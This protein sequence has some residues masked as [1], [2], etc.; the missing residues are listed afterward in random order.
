MGMPTLE[1][2]ITAVT[3]NRKFSKALIRHFAAIQPLKSLGSGVDSSTLPFDVLQLVFVDKSEDQTKV[4]GCN[5]DRLFQVEVP[6]PDERTVD[7]G[8][9]SAF[10]KA[11]AYQVQRALT[12]CGLPPQI[13]EQLLR[14]NSHWV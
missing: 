4:I 9:T 14:E 1:I 11:V 5:G 13:E 3:R 6:I 2:S 7:F 10:V 8:D 12:R